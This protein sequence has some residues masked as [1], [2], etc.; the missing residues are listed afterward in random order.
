VSAPSAGGTYPR[1]NWLAAVVPAG[2]RR[3]RVE[4]PALGSTLAEAG[5][6]L[7]N[8]DPHAEIA[9]I[10]GIRGDAAAAIIPLEALLPEGGSRPV[11]ALRRTAGFARIRVQAQRSKRALE[12]RGYKHSRVVPWEWE[13]VVG[14]PG[15]RDLSQSLRL[16]ERMPL[17]ALVVG[18]KREEPTV[19]DEAL[20][21]AEKESGE[22]VQTGWPLV[23]QGGLVAIGDTAVLR[24]AIGPAARELSL[25]RAA[26]EALASSSPP[27]TVVERVPRLIARGRTGLADWSLEQRLP[28][29]VPGAD[30]T[31]ALLAD[32][33]EFLA[34]LHLAGRGMSAREESFAEMAAIVAETCAPQAAASVHELGASLDGELEEVPRG[35]GHGDFWTRN[36]LAADGRLTGVVDWH[37]GSPGRLP[38]VDLLHLR[39]S[40]VFQRRRQYLGEALVEHLLPWARSG[41]DEVLRA[42]CERIGVEL[43]PGK[44]EALV[45]AY[46]LTR[47]A[48][49]LQI[50]ADRIER[51]RWLQGN[52]R[53]VVRALAMAF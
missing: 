53:T 4:D 26:L 50:Y 40:A 32:C 47:T 13:Q 22:R 46:W 6:E 39:L 24:V 9:S 30:L 21:D 35:F 14:L 34:E 43:D 19:F 49:E 41:G 42:Y 16:P 20:A 18:S 37:L 8:S 17:G 31:S 52:V 28:G 25:L 10:A 44:L 36:L 27:P 15:P 23:R 1:H 12:Q 2:A 33:V 45:K 7:V 5:A 3:F 51:P 29:S 38:V 48:R 11:R